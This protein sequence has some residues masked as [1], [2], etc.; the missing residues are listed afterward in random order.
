VDG[1]P[2]DTHAAIVELLGVSWDA[3][4]ASPK[5]SRGRSR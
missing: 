3:A 2:L 5:G 1:L 4:G